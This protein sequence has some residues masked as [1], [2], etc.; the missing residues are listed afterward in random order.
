MTSETSGA[1][2]S[3]EYSE[4]GDTA[5]TLHLWTQ[6]VGK[7]RLALSPW[8]NHSWHVTLYPS[9]RGF[10]TGPMF[11]E[12]KTLELELDFVHHRLAMTTS[13]GDDRTIEL[14]PMSVAAFYREVMKELASLGVEPDFYP[15][16]NEVA[17][18]I[19]FADDETHAS[20]D[21]DQAHS[22][23]VAMYSAARVMNDFRARYLGKCSAVRFFWGSFDL[24]VTRF[25]GRAAPPHPGG[26][27][28][29]PDWIT[30]EAYSH[31]V[32]S[33]G[34]WP[35]N[36]DVPP[37]FYS[38]AYPTPDTFSERPVLPEVATFNTELGEFVLPY[39][40]V[41]EAD[42][43]DEALMSFLQSTYDAAASSGDWD[44]E[45]LEFNAPEEA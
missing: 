19:P 45:T 37:I 6:I 22:F 40:S 10:T 30:R 12:D 33:A 28:G 11:L 29:L 18:P 13:T 7:V 20:Y 1:W 41:R 39:D 17:D 43:P 23:F 3:L 38:Y 36:A 27:P 8:L 32:S 25:S 44:R 26:I 15:V 21:A 5:Q 14:R 34:F 24:A 35:G 16:P 2:P 4:W 9:A 42:A 31:E